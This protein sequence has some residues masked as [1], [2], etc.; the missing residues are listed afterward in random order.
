MTEAVAIDYLKDKGHDIDVDTGLVTD[1][2]L[3]ELI[4]VTAYN[5]DT[6]IYLH[7]YEIGEQTYTF[8]S[9]GKTGSFF[10]YEIE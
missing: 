9:T 10:M 1:A 3:D 6:S 4:T 5:S 8:L 2:Q 7:S